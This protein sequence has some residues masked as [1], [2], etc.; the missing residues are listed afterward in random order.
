MKWYK[1]LIWFALWAGAALLAAQ[2]IGYLTG[3][4][5]RD[6]SGLTAD[7]VY[8]NFPGLRIWDKIYGAG[9]LLLAAFNVFTRFRLSGFKANGPKCLYFTY[10]LQA[11]LAVVNAI[12]VATITGVSGAVNAVGAAVICAALIILN[13][14]YFNKRGELFVN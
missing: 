11:L 9:L 8:G 5:Y 7:T 3:A 2:G 12:T 4:S 1:F 13:R 14:S 10:A 6:G